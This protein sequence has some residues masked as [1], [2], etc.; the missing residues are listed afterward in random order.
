MAKM[1]PKSFF[2]EDAVS[3]AK[4]LIGKYLVRRRT[5]STERFLILETEGYGGPE[6]LASHARFGER[7]RSKIMFGPAGVWYVYLVYGIHEML[8]IVTGKEKEAGAVLIRAV[9][10]AN[11][12]GKL[13]KQLGIGRKLNG[14]RADRF[15]GFWFERGEELLI[16]ALPRVGV[17]YA[18]PI[19][20]K[21]KY[22]FLAKE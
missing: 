7:G 15:S 1:L 18:G 6:D 8:N 12:P 22:R 16:K 4:K 21:K 9:K 13:T 10:G 2:E 19:W 17:D 5:G 11:G 20:S 3:V 14:L